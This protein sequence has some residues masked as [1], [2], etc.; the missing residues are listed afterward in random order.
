MTLLILT[1]VTLLV[2]LAAVALFARSRAHGAL[3]LSLDT[4][5]T[6]AVVTIFFYIGTWVFV[7]YYLRYVVVAGYVGVA[8]WR[9]LRWRRGGRRTLPESAA[10][11]MLAKSAVAI[12]L[13]WLCVLAWIGQIAPPGTSVDLAFPLAAGRYC[14]IQGGRNFITNPFHNFVDSEYAIDIVKV[15]RIGNR[16]RSIS[17]RDATRYE[18]FGETVYSPIEGTVIAVTDTLFDNPP[19]R[20]NPLSPLGNH[21]V[22]ANGDLRVIVA[23]L[24]EGSATVRVGAAIDRG[25]PIGQ[26]GNSGYSNEPH[27]HVQVL[28]VQHGRHALGTPVAF[29]LEGRFLA[30]NDM[31]TCR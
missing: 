6:G 25:T 20:A 19:P 14:V 26:V 22:I 4:V 9:W 13:V 15:N 29:R 30:I 2:P 3:G 12:I 7:S 11:A 27:L 21:I 17:P 8:G 24:H 18:I 28:R 31:V 1:F 16:A 10:T 23:H 5:I